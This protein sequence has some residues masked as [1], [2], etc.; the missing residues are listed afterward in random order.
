LAAAG[1]VK[2]EISLALHLKPVYRVVWEVEKA[3]PRVAVALVLA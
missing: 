1:R 3:A 2:L